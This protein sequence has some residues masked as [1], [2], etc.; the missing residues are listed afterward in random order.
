MAIDLSLRTLAHKG[1]SAGKFILVSNMEASDGG[2]AIVA[3]N[4]RA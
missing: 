4:E 1:E 2:N 3:G